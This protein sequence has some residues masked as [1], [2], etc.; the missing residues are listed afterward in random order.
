MLLDVLDALAP[1]REAVILIGAQAVY[2]RTGDSGLPVAPHTTDADLALDPEFLLDDPQLGPILRA[3]GFESDPINVGSWKQ[4]QTASVVDLMVPEAV[5]GPG[6]RGARLG[7]HGDH[8]ARKGRG[9]EGALVDKTK[10]LLT[11]L[12]IADEREVELWVAG[13]AALLVAKLHKLNERVG[14]P[15]RLDDKDALDIYRLL[16]AVTTPE[17]ATGLD[18]CLSDPRS[19]EVTREAIRF[20]RELFGMAEA[21]GCQ[22]AARA[23][24]PLADPALVTASCVA[25][26][27]D[28]LTE[29][30]QLDR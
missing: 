16:Q 8:I 26:A 20:L 30:G 17:L 10:E 27:Q 6:R 14:S 15:T 2:L 5:G 19:T 18:L 24:I 25:L 29:V 9:L 13:S 12:D 4:A 7:L 21:P 28:L 22:M 3:A 23:L 1:H 11:A